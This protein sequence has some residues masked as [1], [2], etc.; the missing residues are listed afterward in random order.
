MREGVAGLLRDKTRKPGKKPLPAATVQ[1]VVDLALGARQEKRPTGPGGCW[2][3]RL[4]SA[5]DRCNASSRPTDSHRTVSA[6]SSCPTT[7]VRRKAQGRRRPLRRSSRPCRR[8]LGRREEPDP[9]A[10]PHPAG[11]ADEAGARRHHDARLQAAWH[12]HA[13]CRA[14]R[15]RRHRHRPQHAAPPAPG[16]HPLPQHHRGAGAQ[17]KGDPRHRRQLCHP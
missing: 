11:T 3:R 12:H 4:A 7:R 17:A 5:C 10:R 14:Q 13:V 9:G 6:P 2:P 8:P 1:R 15:A 16:V